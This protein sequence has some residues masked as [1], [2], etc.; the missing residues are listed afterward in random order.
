MTL[1]RYLGRRGR[2]MITAGL[3]G[4]AGCTVGPDFAPPATPLADAGD[5]LDTGLVAATPR[6]LLARTIDAEPDVA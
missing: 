4:L 2:A 1:S 6:R 3:L 5:Y